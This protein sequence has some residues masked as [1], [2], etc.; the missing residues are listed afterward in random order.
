VGASGLSVSANASTVA[1]VGNETIQ[2][3][4]VVDNVTVRLRRA[5]LA[6]EIKPG[7]RINVAEL[8]KRFGVSHIP[9]R[10]AVRRLETEGLIVALPQRAAVAAGVDLADLAG[11]YDLRRIIECEVIRRSVAA[12][13]AEQV[14][15]ARN[16]LAGLE[17][18]AA[19]H[20]SPTFWERHRDF[21]WALLD[22]GAS[23]WIERTLDQLWLASQRY[24]RLFVSQTISDAMSEHRQLVEC[25][26]RRDS[27]R[28]AEILRR[29]LDRTELA[30]RQ[31]F[32][33]VDGPGGDGEL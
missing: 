26:E 20:D 27:A 2:R 9:I 7:E 3:T 32:E 5:L 13:T 8:E 31:A 23:A 1:S 15:A 25:C 17:A 30:V 18:V 16:A 29:H 11:L 10:E 19:D 33:P 24:V 14:E 28:A 12:M 22:P 4:S 6:G 21:H